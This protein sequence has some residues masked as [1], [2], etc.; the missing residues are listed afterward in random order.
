[1]TDFFDHVN[2][3]SRRSSPS[4]IR[5]EGGDRGAFTMIELM[6]VISIISI[7][8]SITA[9][10]V[11]AAR[12]S[13]RRLDC[14]NRIRQLALGV[15]LFHG[16]HHAI[17]NNGG[18]TPGNLLSLVGGTAVQPSTFDR[19]INVRFSWGVGDSSR[20][21]KQQTGSWSFSILPFVELGDAY[22]AGSV[23][24][25]MS[26]FNCPS[27]SRGKAVVPQSD[28]HGIY[29]SGGLAMTKSDYGANAFVVPNRPRLMSFRDL[30]DGLSST[31]LL[32]EKSFDPTV[33]T[34][35]SWYW[36]EPIWIGGSKGSARSGL[37]VLPD[38]PGIP[39]KENWG[40]AHPGGAIFAFADGHVQFLS[41]SVDW[42]IM[43]ATLSPNGRETETLAK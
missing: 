24:A 26:V 38:R 1:M 28:A 3:E 33:Q 36:D 21:A 25:P 16:N 11:Q 23:S 30:V 41:N 17:P 15:E 14:Q 8:I 10:A 2:C 20:S 18:A 34:P 19:E 35:T 39:Y 5:A 13:A 32:G 42:Q 43:A 37:Q 22:S 31:I 40:S 12:E 29:E 9:P 27:R 7:L 4:K 6:V